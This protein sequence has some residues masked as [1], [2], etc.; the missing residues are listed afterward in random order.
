MNGTQQL[1]IRW[2]V[3]PR[4]NVTELEFIA[5]L[6]K[7]TTVKRVHFFVS[8]VWLAGNKIQATIGLL[9]DQ[10]YSRKV[11]STTKTSKKS[12]I[13]VQWWEFL[14]FSKQCG[15]EAHFNKKD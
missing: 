4:I 13:A 3:S 1:N 7:L 5:T 6:K 10:K 11:F 15:F 8:S 2:N 9:S 12:K 14:F